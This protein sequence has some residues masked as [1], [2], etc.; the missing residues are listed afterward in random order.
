M[1]DRQISGFIWLIPRRGITE[2]KIRTSLK[3]PETQYQIAFQQGRNI[4]LL[5]AVPIKPHSSEHGK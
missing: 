2:S 5:T 3:D 1:S 4:I